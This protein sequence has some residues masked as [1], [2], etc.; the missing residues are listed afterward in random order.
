MFRG[1]TE[2]MSET[3]S[4]IPST[5]WNA[6][7]EATTEVR[8][9]VNGKE[10]CAVVP[11]RLLL[12]DFLRDC[13]GLTALKVSCGEGACGACTVIIDGEPAR[14]CTL[15]AVQSAGAQIV[16]LEGLNPAS[17]L[18]PVQQLFKER[19]ALQCGYCT[20]GLLMTVQCMIARGIQPDSGEV[21]QYLSGHL[22]RCTGY[23]NILA[24][25]RSALRGE[26]PAVE[27]ENNG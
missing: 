4:A 13:L 10:V 17:G 19:H 12:S 21:A 9:V 1:A 27:P 16:T 8:V 24:A 25:V 14:S 22:C 7:D 15:L 26:N 20:P 3:V 18:N 6:S 2:Y 11:D 5:V 23:R